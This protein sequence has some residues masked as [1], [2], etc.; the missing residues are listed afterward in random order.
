MANGNPDLEQIVCSLVTYL[1]ILF[2]LIPF[3]RRKEAMIGLSD[4]VPNTTRDSC[5]NL[6]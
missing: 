1:E 2:I 6:V 5:S 4:T 3:Q